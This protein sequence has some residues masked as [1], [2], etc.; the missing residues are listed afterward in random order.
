[1][2]TPTLIDA[3][4]VAPQAWLNGAGTTRVLLTWPEG[5]DW[6]LRI[7]LAHVD[8]DAEFS[9]LPGIER[10]FGVVDGAGVELKFGDGTQGMAAGSHKLKPGDP[11]LC[12][13][14]ASRVACR[15]LDGPTRDLNLMLR[16]SIG[17][18]HLVLEGQAWTPPP[19]A[20]CGLFSAVAGQCDGVTVPALSLLWFSDAPLGLSF[21][22]AQPGAG[23]GPLGWWLFAT[24]A[25]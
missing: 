18:M 13:D 15:L 5:D 8:Q 17:A 9:Q 4:S 23:K 24:P 6:R 10:W 19:H 25:G 16:G 22:A 7:S 14:G 3:L 11:P 2:S 21:T 1:M 20:A 12:F